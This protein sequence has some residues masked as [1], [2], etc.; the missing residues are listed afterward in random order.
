M[1]LYS[2][3]DDLESYFYNTEKKTTAGSVF[4]YPAFFNQIMHSLYTFLDQFYWF[5]GY[6]S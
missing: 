4:S 1:S 5:F 3:D 6:L 2:N